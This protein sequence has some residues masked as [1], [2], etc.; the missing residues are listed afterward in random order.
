MK[1]H[2]GE[3]VID[4]ALFRITSAGRD[5]PAEPKV[6]DLLVYLVEHRDRVISREELFREVWDGREVTD[7]TLSNHVKSARRVLGDDGELQRIIQTVRGRGYQFV[8]P[9]EEFFPGS[10]A[11]AGILR[12]TPEI[13]PGGLATR[14][15][16]LS[17]PL[18]LFLGLLVIA[19]SL[20]EE[21][22]VIADPPAESL[23]P[24][25]LVVPFEVSG[26]GQE[27]WAPFA[28]QVTREVIRNLRKISGLR[29]VPPPSAFT[30][31]DNKARDAIRSQM[32][33]V[34]YVLDAVISVGQQ[35]SIRI[36]PE[37]ED[38]TTGS[39][40]WDDDYQGRIDDT[41]FFAI[42]S[43]IAASVSESLQVLILE[44][45]Q[46]ALG[47]L[48]TTNL[49][50]YELYIT[51]RQ[52]MEL[53]N[54]DSLHRAITLFDEAIA[55]DGD[56]AAAHVARADANRM[57]M[58]YFEPPINM[59]PAVVDS[60]TEA[61][62]IDPD[63]AEALSSLGL[64]YVLAWRWDDAW[65]ILNEARSRDAS[66]ALTE[67]GFALYYAGLGDRQGVTRSVAAANRLDP[68]NI[69][70]ADWGQWAL[71]MVGEAEAALRW[72]DEKI[73]QH[74]DVGLVYSGAGITASLAGE[75][76]RAIALGE[77]GVELE[78]NAPIALIT[79]AQLYG[80]AG[81]A[82]KVMPLLEQA[83]AIGGYMCPYETAVAWLTLGEFDRVFALLD[84]AVAYRSNCLVFLRSDPRMA[85]LKNDPRYTALLARVGLDDTAIAGYD[86]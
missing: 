58:T 44:D 86:R 60:V 79:L 71:N 3:F 9:V 52:Q 76:E 35:N 2:S 14:W 73:R 78:P 67:L 59:L 53:F 57:L 81:Q 45:E 28:D 40:V 66:L 48:P 83:E 34:R 13:A 72:G 22:G 32:P 85:P 8:A 77:R 82:E 23:Q 70:L 24:Y 55:L 15:Y 20:N 30:F 18:A 46:R 50:A 21:T 51:G 43:E 6:F 69:E 16:Y 65:T 29:V 36:T 12:D 54:Q 63:S 75:H 74:P 5:V 61:L 64:A 42:Q 41:N 68:L 19:A 56:F 37:L 39:L 49:A 47:E 7:A 11:P 62:A 27:Q 4:T 33:D 31:R 25:I 84:D 38:L 10:D 80:A 26:D 1:Y 17:L